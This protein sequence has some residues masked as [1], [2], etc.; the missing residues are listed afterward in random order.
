MRFNARTPL[1][2]IKQ[3]KYTLAQL[4]QYYEENPGSIHRAVVK[5]GVLQTIVEDARMQLESSV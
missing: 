4:L 5:K 3:P 1:K 2:D